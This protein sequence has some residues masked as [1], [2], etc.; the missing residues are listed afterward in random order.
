MEQGMIPEVSVVD[1]VKNPDAQAMALTGNTM[2]DLQNIAKE[3]GV[4]V[5]PSS[6]EIVDKSQ[7]V[8]SPQE[9]APAA[10][11][12]PEPQ[13]E[14]QA[15]EAPKV[16]V[17]AKFQNPDGTTNTEKVAKA[18][19]SL[20]QAIARYKEKEKEFSRLQNKVNNPQAQEH[21]SVPRLPSQLSPLEVQV[22]EDLIAESNAL[23]KP[24]EQAHA[25]AQ[26]RVIAKIAQAKHQADSDLVEDIR[27]RV[28]DT[29]R[30]NELQTMFNNHPELREPGMVDKLVAIRNQYPEVN[31]SKTPW[32]SAFLVQKGLES[33]SQVKTPT[34][35]GGTAKAPATPVSPVSRVV[36]N[37]SPATLKDAWN[38]DLKDLE[39]RARAENP[40]MRL[41]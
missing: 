36:S 18:E 32:R 31:A 24:M 28:E 11:K 15:D 26:A 27:R 22:A 25:I 38:M 4:Q 9:S 20:D 12:A 16:D 17:P 39:A 33:L 2:T 35:K 37:G 21:P 8:E 30:T 41:K 3:M 5:D 34:P 10:V 6:G 29:E 13:P 7:P 1:S 19:E 40:G 14:P 23:G